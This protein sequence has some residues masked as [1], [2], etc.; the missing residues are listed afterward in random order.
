[1]R[2][3]VLLAT[4]A[5]VALPSFAGAQ[6]LVL[7]EPEALARLSPSS[8]RVR[9]IRSSVD[10]ARADALAARRWP[11]PRVTIDRESVAGTTEYITTVGQL[12]PVNGQRGLQ[13]RAASALVDASSSRA[14]EEMRR[15]RAE[16]RLAFAQLAA[17]QVRERELTAARDRR[18]LAMS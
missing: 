10:V 14:D 16:L 12:L 18:E 8:P 3:V 13:V 9:A 11:N 6:S 5:A 1:M 15:V 4:L 7:T 2:V 17:A